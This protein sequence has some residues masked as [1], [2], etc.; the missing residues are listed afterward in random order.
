MGKRSFTIAIVQLDPVPRRYCPD[1]RAEPPMAAWSEG[2]MR[3]VRSIGGDV[4]GAG[5]GLQRRLVMP[6]WPC[7]T[8][9]RQV[10][11]AQGR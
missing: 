5:V 6:R 7:N 8:Q 11:C 10:I 4:P 3:A 2:H 1:G 9:P